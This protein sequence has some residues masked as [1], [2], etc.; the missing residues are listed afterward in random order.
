MASNFG[1]K[2][3]YNSVPVKDNCMLFSPTAYFQAQAIRWYY[4]NLSPCNSRCHG[5]E[6]LDKI[7]YNSVHVK[8]NC[9]LF[10]PT[11]LFLGPSYA[12]V[13]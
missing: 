3:D 6:F 12:I 4:L 11:S 7:D 5:N 9:M 1:K 10:S 8:N 2:F 13:L